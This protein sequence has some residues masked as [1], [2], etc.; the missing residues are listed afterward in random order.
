MAL[1]PLAAVFPKIAVPACLW[2]KQR[3]PGDMDR[4]ALDPLWP[5]CLLVVSSSGMHILVVR[6]LDKMVAQRGIFSRLWER[7]PIIY[8]AHSFVVLVHKHDF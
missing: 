2:A 5:G 3:E 8:A 6:T 4:C 7:S 1:T